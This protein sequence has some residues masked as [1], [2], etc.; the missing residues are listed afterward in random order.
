MNKGVLIIGLGSQSKYI[1]EIF[2][3][4]G[5]KIIGLIA[6]PFE[7]YAQEEVY[8]VR[9]LGSLNDFKNIYLENN[10]PYL[11]LACSKNKIKEE[12]VKDLS[13]YFPDYANAVHPSAV[14]ATTARL[15]KGVIVNPNAVIQPYV[16]IG[17]HVMIHAGV[18]VEHDCVI[19]D[20]VNLAPRVALTGYV[21]V[22]KGSTIYT[23]AVV[24]PGLT[25]GEYSRVSAGSVVMSS[26]GDNITFKGH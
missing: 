4:N 10:S 11:M 6:L 21:R 7:T 26:I 5:V 17:D 9:V 25:I 1:I 3:L 18:I 15:G 12:L 8:G 20:F 24:S 23:G 13:S 22:G 19:S 16:S 2:R 14:I